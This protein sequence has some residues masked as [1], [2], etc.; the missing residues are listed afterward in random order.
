MRSSSGHHYVGLDHLRALAAFM[1]VAWHFLHFDNGTPVPFEGAP[2][3]IP[4]ALIDEGHTGVS[5]FM[6]LSGYLFAK[7]LDGKDIEYSA[8]FWNRLVRLAPLL[9]VVFVL[10]GAQH[11]WYGGSIV[12]YLEMLAKGLILPVWPNGGWSITTEIHFYLLLPFLMLLARRS[13]G[14]PILLV[15]AAMALRTA[16][17]FFY[18]EVQ[19]WSYWTIVGRI[20]Q[21]VLGIL[22]FL[23][24]P[25]ILR[26]GKL[27]LSVVMAFVM[28]WWWFN[29]AGGFYRLP[30]YP[31]NQPIWIFLPTIEGLA[32]ALLVVWYDNKASA[33]RTWISSL[34]Q[35]M[36]EYSYS[37]Y[38]LHVFFVFRAAAWID[39][40]VMDIS[41]F[42]LGLVWATLFFL[43]MLI[44]G[45]LSYRFIE[46]PFLRLR[47]TYVRER[48]TLASTGARTGH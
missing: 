4:L 22:A 25:L 31:S 24:T 32:Y 3:V 10:A 40:H 43:I 33:R 47:R 20:D 36:G 13:N 14:L 38:L 6:V 12:P 23:Y 42:Y 16:L 30:S 44:P 37:I 9:L 27:T 17:F 46:R 34:A 28:F 2:A 7:L 48:T 19:S 35:R 29:M 11:Y 18:G 15:A 45:Y 5:L 26:H 41:N 1:V 39:T 8:F 21:F